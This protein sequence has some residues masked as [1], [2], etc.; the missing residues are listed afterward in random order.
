MH[1]R[2]CRAEA[3][4]GA[5]ILAVPASFCLTQIFAHLDE[6]AATSERQGDGAA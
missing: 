3:R 2:E 5:T 6:P 1:C 4:P